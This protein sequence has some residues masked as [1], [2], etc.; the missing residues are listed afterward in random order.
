MT[1]ATNRGGE[2]SVRE[3]AA[4][5]REQ[6]ADPVIGVDIESV[7]F[8]FPSNGATTTGEPGCTVMLAYT[9]ESGQT[10]TRITRGLSGRGLRRVIDQLRQIT[11]PKEGESYEE[12]FT[13]AIIR[14][15]AADNQLPEDVEPPADIVDGTIE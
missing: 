9:T 12:K 4:R 11:K 14:A 2:K 13:A 15:L 3:T 5:V 6:K 7:L 10:A 1:M 8:T